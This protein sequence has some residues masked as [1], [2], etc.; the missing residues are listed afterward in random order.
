MA[1]R[2]A[3][4]LLAAFLIF[5]DVAILGDRFILRGTAQLLCAVLGIWVL[6][7]LRPAIMSRYILIW[8]YLLFLLLSPF[9]DYDLPF[10]FQ[11][12]SLI[13]VVLFFVAFVETADLRGHTQF[14]KTV[15]YCWT[16]VCALGLLLSISHPALTYDHGETLLAEERFRGLFS[17]PGM[18]GSAAG[19]LV[20]LGIFNVRG[21]ALRVVVV[22]VGVTSV[23]MTG[24][25][26]FWAATLL[27]VVVATWLYR[28]KWRLVMT[29][30]MVAGASV[31]TL[32]YMDEIPGG[33]QLRRSLRMESIANLT[34]R[35]NIWQAAFEAVTI[36]PFA[37]FGFTRGAEGLVALGPRLSIYLPTLA[38]LPAE[39]LSRVSFHNGYI[40]ALMDSGYCGFLLYVLVI[41]IAILKV[42]LYD[43]H[44][45][46]AAMFYCL[47]FCAVANFTEVV[48]YSVSVFHSALFWYFCVGAFHLSRPR[49]P[50]IHHR[51]A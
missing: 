41:S 33:D 51:S 43:Q 20:G 37:G 48:V 7:N 13:G 16:V 12:F 18:L 26:T 30:A 29:C 46:N 23:L 38:D 22:A 50:P 32:M 9:P 31:L 47:L 21:I 25:R 35:T 14:I 8:S 15:V 45:K 36:H 42:F 5:K 19:L 6:L 34:G 27:A 2:V 49:I 40:Q 28:P 39:A 44:R 3:S 4:I 24:S 1:L 11:V 10:L 17:K